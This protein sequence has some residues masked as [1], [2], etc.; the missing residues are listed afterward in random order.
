M[1]RNDDF[2]GLL[3]G[4]L[5]EHEGNTPCPRTSV[6]PSVPS[7]LRSSASGL[8]AARRTPEMNTFAKFGLAAAAVVVAALLGYN[9]LVAPN[10]GGPGLDDPSPT[11]VPTPTPQSIYEGVLYPATYMID[12]PIPVRITLDVPDGWCTWATNS[13]VVGLVVDNVVDNRVEKCNSGWGPA[14]WI[15]DN[16]YS[17]PCDPNSEFEPSLGPSVDDLV[18]ALA[19]LPGYEASTPTDITVSGFP[20]VQLELTAPEYGDECPDHRTWS[21]AAA[22]HEPWSLARPIASKFSMWMASGSC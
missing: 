11:P 8:V 10:V 15:V 17:D 20:G 12:D 18:T 19:N 13:D 1:T 21:T 9:Y 2:I 6:T 7:F 16:V 3:E 14:F 4:Y 22:S 5:D